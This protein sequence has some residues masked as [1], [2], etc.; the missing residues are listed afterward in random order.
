[1]RRFIEPPAWLDRRDKS[2]ARRRPP[3]PARAGNKKAR[4][5]PGFF[6]R[7]LDRAG[8]EGPYFDDDFL[9]PPRD[10]VDLRADDFED[11][12]A[13]DFELERDVDF[14]APPDLEPD[15]DDDFDD[16]LVAGDFA[17][18]GC[19]FVPLKQGTG[20]ASP[21]VLKKPPSGLFSLITPKP[22]LSL[23]TDF[24]RARFLKC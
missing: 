21:A 2:T 5:K 14:L 1:M 16:F 3:A 4:R 7:C 19:P 18:C 6:T 17:I 23:S 12:F 13:P 22:P 11:F 9:E 20:I 10:E 8:L 15:R 24:F